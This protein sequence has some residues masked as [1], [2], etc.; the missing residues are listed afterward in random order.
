MLQ[1]EKIGVMLHPYL[2]ITANSVLSSVPKLAVVRFPLLG[3]GI[4]SIYFLFGDKT[5]EYSR[6]LLL[7]SFILM[8]IHGYGSVYFS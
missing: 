3:K 8:N 5:F 6:L 2:L 4:L 1:P 7:N